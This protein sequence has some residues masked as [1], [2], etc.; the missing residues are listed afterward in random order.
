MATFISSVPKYTRSIVRSNTFGK[1][2]IN[3]IISVNK[4]SSSNDIGKVQ[5]DSSSSMD[6]SLDNDHSIHVNTEAYVFSIKNFRNL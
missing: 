6:N 5:I 4:S 3:D 2:I 1:K